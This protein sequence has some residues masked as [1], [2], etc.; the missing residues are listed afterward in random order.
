MPTFRNP[1]E[2]GNVSSMCEGILVTSLHHRLRRIR[3]L[4]DADTDAVTIT[5]IE[6]IPLVVPLGREY[7]GSY[8]SRCSTPTATRSGGTSS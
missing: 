8:Y 2:S 7:K 6:Q 4:P 3:R 1:N 5:E